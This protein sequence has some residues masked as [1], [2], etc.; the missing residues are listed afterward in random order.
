MS[1]I[2]KPTART[3]AA[4][5]SKLGFTL[6][7]VMMS[8]AIAGSALVAIF[9]MQESIARGNGLGRE[10]TTATANTRLWLERLRRDSLTWTG[11]TA[12]SLAQTSY[13]NQVGTGWFMPVPNAPFPNFAQQPGVDWAGNETPITGDHH[14]C[15]AIRLQ[16][17]RQPETMRADVITWWARQG[18]MPCA[19]TGQ[20]LAA[21]AS[22]A[23]GIRQVSASTILR[24]GQ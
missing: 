2:A 17:V 19:N 1:Q 6:I 23:G 20:A 5:R 14:F 7:E 21:L 8:L 13:L 9:A 18:R 10:M 11:N 24:R 16:W 15:T 3:R 4:K 22:P 12:T